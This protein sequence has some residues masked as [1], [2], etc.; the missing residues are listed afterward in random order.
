MTYMTEER[1]KDSQGCDH[2]VSRKS[3]LLHFTAG[4]MGSPWR[5]LK[6]DMTGVFPPCGLY[7]HQDLKQVPLTALPGT[8]PGFSTEESSWFIGQSV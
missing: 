1:V 7:S 4:E 6:N 5:V 2:M 8:E 3:K